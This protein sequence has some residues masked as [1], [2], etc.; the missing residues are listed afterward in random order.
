VPGRGLWHRVRIGPFHT[1]FEAQQ[2]RKKFEQTE[3]L[4]PFMVDPVKV[5]Q[6]EDLRAAKI[7]ARKKK[8]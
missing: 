2:Y 7:E 4:S 5:E 3:H 1:G 6:A 8:P